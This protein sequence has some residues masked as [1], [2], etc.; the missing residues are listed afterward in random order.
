MVFVRRIHPVGIG[1]GSNKLEVKSVNQ[2]GIEGPVS[3]AIV[4]VI[5]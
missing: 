3:T 5:K 1:A 4:D 2:F